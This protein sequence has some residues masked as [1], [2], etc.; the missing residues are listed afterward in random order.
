[1]WRPQTKEAVLREVRIREWRAR[2][3]HGAKAAVKAALKGVAVAGVTV[4]HWLRA[5]S[6]ATAYEVEL[7]RRMSQRYDKL[8]QLGEQAYALYRSGNRSFEALVP[9]CEEIARL[10]STLENARTQRL[11]VV[12]DD[13]P[14]T[15]SATG[16]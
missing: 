12:A 3:W 11:I 16:S 8:L 10:D 4:V 7:N 14:A 9:L 13:R 15:Q 1:M 6:A 2:L 5:W